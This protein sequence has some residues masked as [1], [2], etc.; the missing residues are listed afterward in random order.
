M[1]LSYLGAVDTITD[2]GYLTVAATIATV[3]ARHAAILNQINGA[4]PFPDSFDNA[5][6]PVDI[7]TS[8]MPLIITCPYKIVTPVKASTFRSNSTQ[9]ST[10]TQVWTGFFLLIIMIM[11]L[12]VL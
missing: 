11:S 5:T 10:A 3:E 9:S 2:E 7:V 12:V 4:T 6:L 8:V 1:F